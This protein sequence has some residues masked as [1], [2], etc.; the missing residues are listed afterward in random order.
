[1]GIKRTLNLKTGRYELDK[2]KRIVWT[3]LGLHYRMET[4]EKQV[5][6]LQNLLLK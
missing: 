4:L 5:A 2:P 3:T 1:M 6:Q